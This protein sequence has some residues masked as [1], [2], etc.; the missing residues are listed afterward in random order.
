[1][2]LLSALELGHHSDETLAGQDNSGKQTKAPTPCC[3][4]C[5][6]PGSRVPFP[7]ERGEN[8]A[9][10][11]ERMDE[12][13]FVLPQAGRIIRLSCCA[14]LFSRCLSRSLFLSLHF[15]LSFPSHVSLHHSLSFSALA[16][17]R[18]L[19]SG[20]FSCLPLCPSHS[21]LR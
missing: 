6:D 15:S 19:L 8:G 13:G 2:F 5:Q 20:W 1:M 12:K 11:R 21:A 17:P 18:S 7:K 9:R 4:L 10:E 14:S 16:L 3:S